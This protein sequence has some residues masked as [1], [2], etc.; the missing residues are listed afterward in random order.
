M[1]RLCPKEYLYQRQLN[2][3]VGMAIN[4]QLLKQQLVSSDYTMT[5][6]V[7]ESGEFAVRGG[8][9]DIMPMGSPQIIRIEL[10]DDI[11]ESLSLLDPGNRQL[12]GKINKFELVP[13]REYPTDPQSLKSVASKFGEIFKQPEHQ[14]ILKEIN[15]G[16]IPAGSEFYLPL[17]FEQTATIFDYLDKSQWQ[18]VYYHDLPAHF[19]NHWQEINRRYDLYSYQ[20]P[21]L[22]PSLLFIPGDQLISVARQTFKRHIIGIAGSKLNK[23]TFSPLPDISVNNREQQSFAKLENFVK[24]F[25]GNIIL[26]T[27][28]IGRAEI[29]RQTLHNYQFKCKF[30]P[31]INWENSSNEIQIIQA[32]MLGN[33]LLIVATLFSYRL[34]IHLCFYVLFDNSNSAVI[35]ESNVIIEYIEEKHDET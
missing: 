33:Q 12:I 32:N 7:Y 21:C 34:F 14:Y 9:V 31:S 25:N 23:Y 5:N 6:Q 18:V 15:N 20:Y 24:T 29:L 26:I 30:V 3:E 2:L 35:S 11:V 28:S 27:D 8:I 22:K 4:L 10:F 19:D 13:A 1:S 16:I 17:F